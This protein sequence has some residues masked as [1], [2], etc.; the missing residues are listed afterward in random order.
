[1]NRIA[2]ACAIVLQRKFILNN[3]PYDAATVTRMVRRMD[4]RRVHL[5]ML[6]KIQDF[7]LQINRWLLFLMSS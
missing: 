1:M 2:K 3:E 7:R 5:E 4:R 6:R